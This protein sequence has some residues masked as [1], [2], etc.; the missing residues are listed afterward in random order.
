MTSHHHH[1]HHHHHVRLSK[2]VIRNQTCTY[3]PRCIIEWIEWIEF[4]ISRVWWRC[5]FAFTEMGRIGSHHLNSTNKRCYHVVTSFV[6]WIQ[7][8]AA[9]SSHFSKCKSTS[10]SFLFVT[11][12]ALTRGRTDQLSNIFLLCDFE[13]WPVILTYEFDLHRVKMN[14]HT[15]YLSQRSFHSKVIF[16]SDTDRHTQMTDCSTPPL[17]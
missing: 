17:K 5:W 14:N 1:H 11:R 2:V 6:S 10:S 9:N 3:W 12:T 4:N 7:V 8:M 15:K 13:L 16:H